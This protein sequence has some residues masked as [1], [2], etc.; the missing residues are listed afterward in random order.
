MLRFSTLAVLAASVLL[1]ADTVAPKLDKTRLESYLR[2]TEGF[3]SGVKFVIDDPAPSAYKGYYRVVVHLSMNG[4][5]VGDRVYYVTPDG[6]HFLNGSLWDL[7]ENPFLDTLERLPADGPSFGPANAKVTIVVFSDFQCPFCREFARTVRNEMPR[8]YSNDVRVVFEDFPLETIHPWARAAAEAGDCIA[9]QNQSAF[10]AFHDWI[11][12]HQQEVTAVNLT[13]KV[14]AVVKDQHVDL[15]KLSSCLGTH[16]MAK[17]VETSL[18]EGRRLQVQQTPTAF[19]NGRMV[20]GAVPW[21][22]LDAVIQLELNRPKEIP[23]P[24][25]EKCCEITV[26]TVLKK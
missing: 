4:R 9:D 7:T 22:S 20:A 14:T 19:I 12:E 13:D 8:K 15:A 3:T 5:N 25:V 6:E 24:P 1:T 2:Y 10:W 16:E 17:K 26:P 11:F 23:G 21:T 18:A